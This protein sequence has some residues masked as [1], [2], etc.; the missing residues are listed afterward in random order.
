M[1]QI[2]IL[3]AFVG[4]VSAAICEALDHAITSSPSLCGALIGCSTYLS[5]VFSRR[6]KIRWRG[7]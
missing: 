5:I 4:V 3:L 6:K 7:L 2:I 1:Q